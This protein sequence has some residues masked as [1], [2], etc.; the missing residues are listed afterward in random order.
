MAAASSVVVSAPRVEAASG[1]RDG[2]GLCWPRRGRAA[3]LAAPLAAGRWPLAPLRLVVSERRT[4]ERRSAARIIPMTTPP[5]KVAKRAPTSLAMSSSYG[6]LYRI[7]Q[8]W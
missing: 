2:R 1:A 7:C 8:G 5:A 4:D 6:V 3:P